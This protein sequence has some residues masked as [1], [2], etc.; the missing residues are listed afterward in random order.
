MMGEQDPAHAAVVAEKIIAAH[1]LTKRDIRII[2]SSDFSHYVPE[3]Q[4]KDGDLFAIEALTRLDT[5][6][7]YRR[8]REKRVTACGYGPIS[9][10][11][12]VCKSMGAQEGR[13]IQYG[14]SGDVTGDRSEVVGY[15][16][17]AVI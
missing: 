12:S 14:T 17:F 9:V 2:A 3:A 16:A 7:F 13:L 10:M 15:A 8:I 4:A 11:V 1:L 5:N 6:E